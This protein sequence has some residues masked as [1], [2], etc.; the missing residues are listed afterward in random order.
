MCVCAQLKAVVEKAEQDDS[1]LAT[2]PVLPLTHQVLRQVVG[3]LAVAP[4]VVATCV[5][6]FHLS[7]CLCHQIA[8][9]RAFVRRRVRSWCRQ[10]TLAYAVSLLPP[11][12]PPLLA[13]P[14]AQQLERMDRLAPLSLS[15][16]EV[17]RQPVLLH[18]IE[19]RVNALEGPHLVRTPGQWIIGTTP[20]GCSLVC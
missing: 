19:P 14:G 8:C 7:V 4:L 16:S 12:P 5:C 17:S 13:R 15:T 10:G 6:G 11:T 20:G 9:V 2:A 3:P 18:A 1:S